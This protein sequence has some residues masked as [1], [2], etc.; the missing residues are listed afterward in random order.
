MHSKSALTKLKAILILDLIIVALSTTA[1]FY[2]DA[3]PGAPLS[4]EQIQLVGLQ[5]A[6]TN[7][8][9][10]QSVEVL[11][12]ATNKASEEGTYSAEL[13]LDS[14][15]TQTSIVELSAGETKTVKFTISSESEGPHIVKIGTLEASFTVAN[16]FE[17]S[18][19][20]VNRTEAA[21]NE[22]IGISVKATNRANESGDY[23]LTLLINNEAIQTKTGQ[24]EA[25]TSVSVLFEVVEQTE[26]TYQFKIGSLNGTFKI[27]SAAL[28]PKPAEFQVTN[29][30]I[31]PEVAEPN[32]AVNVTA[33][34]TNV[35]EISGSY[36]AEFSVNSEVKETKTVQLVGGETAKVAF[37]VIP[38]AKGSY[39]IKIGDATGTLSV[40]DPSKIELTSMIVKPYEVWAGDTVTITVR[41]NNPSEESSLS[42]KLK[43]NGEIVETKTLTLMASTAGNVEFAITAPQLQGGNSLAHK[44]EV[45]GMTGGFMVVKNGFHT[46][47]VALSPY[48]N[49]DF[50]LAL[51]DGQVEQH[52]TYWSALL[53][54][55]TYTITMPVTDP[56]GLATWIG[57]EDGSTDLSRKINLITQTSITASY[58]PGSSCPSVYYW[59]GTSYVYVADI[60]NDGWLGY[61]GYMTENGSIVFLGGNPWDH[62]KLDKEQIQPTEIGNESYYSVKL[63]QRWN[64]LFYL[65]NAYMVVVDHPSD[66]DVYAPLMNYMNPAFNDQIYTVSKNNVKTPISAINEKGTNV[67]SYIS[68]LDGVFTPGNNVLNSPAWNEP[69]SNQLT[70]DLG[71]LS[72][73]SQIKLII[74]GM[75]DWGLAEDYYNWIAKFDKAAAQGLVP[76]GTQITPP[77]YVEVKNS[78]GQWV[79]VSENI[80]MPI[81]ADYVARTFVVD[82]TGI[83]PADISDYQIRLNNFW[84]VTFDYIGID[85]SPQKPVTIQK[86]DPSASLSQ[87]F[88]SPSKASGNFT[89]YGNVTELLLAADDMFVIG[90]QGDEV[91]LLFP[92]DGLLPPAAGMERDYFIFVAC[93]FKD[94]P[95]N[96]G[97]G[98]DFTVEPL[99]FQGMSGFPY[100]SAESYP[101]D[102]EHLMYLREWNTRIIEVPSIQPQ[103]FASSLMAWVTAVIVLLAATN[104]SFLLYFKKR[105]RNV[106]V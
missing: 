2:V 52:K 63:T 47:N 5:I 92:A 13:F 29:L 90:R 40:Q 48:G 44:I 71:D 67:L 54:V 20:A 87:V 33:K 103:A 62:A 89:R 23:S 30:I 7:V 64:E 56:E 12:N 86:I 38:S 42:L 101:Y 72:N 31:D 16:L 93:W 73:A 95:N 91:S 61:T 11:V 85:T 84:N 60:S 8:L 36:T 39:I 15:V 69:I 81:P 50:K 43:L 55:G 57:W 49:A 97:Y 18:D 88:S 94:P 65:D 105:N 80:Q 53:P 6:P 77:P 4:T 96:W 68:E 99:P 74:N 102:E 100:S 51:P 3:L 37:T 34:I 106:A 1:F 70:L 14:V 75:V 35:G 83:F 27:V 76:N 46:L 104:V 98:F 58:N 17:F 9:V 25:G 32:I 79:R 59:N 82:L 28:P 21:V 22:P 41:A 26:G 19:L 78:A 45:N 10:G 24:L 66:S